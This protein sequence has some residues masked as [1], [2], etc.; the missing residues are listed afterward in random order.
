MCRNHSHVA[1][2]KMA[3]YGLSDGTAVYI[4]EPTQEIVLESVNLTG[5]R[6]MV[7][8]CKT[9]LLLQPGP[10]TP[11]YSP[12]ALTAALEALFCVLEASENAS[13]TQTHTLLPLPWPN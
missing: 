11:S 6:F 3:V 10:G 1:V 7:P 9:L 12:E 8:Q 2:D 4:A 13:M 5:A